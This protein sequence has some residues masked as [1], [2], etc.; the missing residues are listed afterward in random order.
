VSTDRCSFCARGRDEVTELVVGPYVTICDG[1]IEA[2]NRM[3]DAVASRPM[4]LFEECTF[5]GHRE[6]RGQ[7]TTDATDIRVCDTCVCL[8]VEILAEQRAA[9]TLPQARLIKG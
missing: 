7:F 6:A 8:C 9:R 2:A 5:C 1:C 4:Q 3:V